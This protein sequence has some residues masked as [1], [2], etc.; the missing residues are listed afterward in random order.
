MMKTSVHQSSD[1]TLY[2]DS[3][4]MWESCTKKGCSRGRGTARVGHRA[5]RYV[6][7][8]LD[9][10]L[11]S[12]VTLGAR[13]S[14]RTLPQKGRSRGRGRSARVGHRAPRYVHQSL[15]ETLYSD[16]T[17]GARASR[18]TLTQ[19][20]RSRGR[21]GSA[22]FGHRTATCVRKVDAKPLGSSE[23]HCCDK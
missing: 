18:R 8:S 10:T 7:Q 23:N 6:H 9:E 20:R 16:V 2:T 13:A 21:G 3:C 17:L 1:V 4:T 14:R 15:D 12:D 22:R 5:P 19:K 11:Y